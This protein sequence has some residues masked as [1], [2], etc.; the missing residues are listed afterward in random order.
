MATA[1]QLALDPFAGSG[2]TGVAARRLG[3]KYL[4]MEL[5]EKY[6]EIARERLRTAGSAT[7]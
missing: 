1:G 6:A 7:R 4:G 2:S 3:R 5:D